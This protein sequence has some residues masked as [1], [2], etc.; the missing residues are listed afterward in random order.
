MRAAVF[1]ELGV[2]CV[3]FIGTAAFTEVLAEVESAGCI[4][5][6]LL[7]GLLLRN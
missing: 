5:G 1:D 4:P 2:H 6:Y 3:N 7:R